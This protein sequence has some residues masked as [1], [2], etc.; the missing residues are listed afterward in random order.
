MRSNRIRHQMPAKTRRCRAAAKTLDARAIDGL[1]AEQARALSGCAGE[2]FLLKQTPECLA[3]ATRRREISDGM[4]AFVR[5]E[6]ARALGHAHGALQ[7]AMKAAA[8]ARA[9]GQGGA[10][11][12]GV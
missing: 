7:R 4:K 8:S 2:R 6:H 1:L 10:A 5:A 9:Q 3:N 11:A 12:G